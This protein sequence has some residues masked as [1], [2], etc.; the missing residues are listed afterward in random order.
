[1]NF[2]ISPQAAMDLEAIYA[3]I[4]ED[5]VAAAKRTIKRIKEQFK[6]VLKFPTIGPSREYIRKH[7]R[8]LPVDNF[9]LYYLLSK[10]E[11]TL[12]RVLR[13]AQDVEGKL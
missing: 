4:A 1:M 10:H 13:A 6:Y 9:V 3:F 8:C 11:I 2:N 7:L 12:V 5:N